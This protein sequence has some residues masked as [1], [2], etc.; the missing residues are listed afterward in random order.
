MAAG[1]IG[2]VGG[3]A[4]GA[5]AVWW[6][7]RRSAPGTPEVRAGAGPHLLPDPALGWLRRAHAALGVWVTELDPQEEGPHAERIVDAERL[8]IGQIMA[9]DRRLERAR[10]QEHGGVERMEQGT[11][12]FQAAGGFAVGLLLPEGHASDAL[13]RAEDDLRRLLDGVRRRPQIVAL[14]QAGTQEASIESVESVA[15]R[16]AYQLERVSGG[17]VLVAAREP[18]GV[19]VVGASGRADRRLL[20]TLAAGDSILARVARG[21]Q[22]RTLWPGDPLGGVVADRRQQAHPVTLLPLVSG[23]EVA[24]AVAIWTPGGEE[25]AG[26]AWGE[27]VEAMTNAAPRILRAVETQQFKQASVLDPLTG[28]PNRRGL[29]GV[30]GRHGTFEGALI[31]ADLDK[32]KSL[33]DTLGHPAGDAAIV[34]FGRIIRE[35]IRNVDT[36]ARIGGEEFA[37]WLPG[38]SLEVGAR[39]AER[40]REKLAGT[41]WDWQ[42]RPWPLTASF[43]VAACPE[44]SRRPENLAGQADAALYAAKHGGRNRVAVAAVPVGG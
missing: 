29:E 36:A 28:L 30:L 31:Y 25:L 43:G 18:G 21:E 14:A 12:V 22:G 19:R 6:L 13:A 27:V 16:L 10:D 8:T 24:G 34:H 41:P 35:Q 1:L 17:G 32:F 42:G 26:K 4:L 23:Q 3:A 20:D 33:N 5:A 38:A 40:I 2:F 11:L 7:D 9:V 44:T 37:V 39:I 15:L